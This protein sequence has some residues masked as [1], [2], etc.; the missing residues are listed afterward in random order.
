[1]CLRLK[2]VDA[3]KLRQYLLE[4]YGVGLISLGKRDLRIAFSCMDED[5]ILE[6]F[7]IILKGVRE[8]TAQNQ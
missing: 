1:M 7:E 6:L 5:E 2:T 8:L 4:T 3:E